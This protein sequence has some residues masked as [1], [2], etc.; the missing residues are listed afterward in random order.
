MLFTDMDIRLLFS[1]FLASGLAS[2]GSGYQYQALM[3][4]LVLLLGGFGA[5][6]DKWIG[7]SGVFVTSIMVSGVIRA[8]ISKRG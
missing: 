2:G 6:N 3:Y 5:D 1:L 8:G 7:L 4:I